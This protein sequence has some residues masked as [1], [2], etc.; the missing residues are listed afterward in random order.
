M[1]FQWDGQTT[2]VSTPVDRSYFFDPKLLTR[3]PSPAAMYVNEKWH[4]LYCSP[5]SPKLNLMQL[6]WEYAYPRHDAQYSGM[7]R[8]G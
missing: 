4:N 5:N 2:A 7:T 8:D 6:Q 1:H 3:R